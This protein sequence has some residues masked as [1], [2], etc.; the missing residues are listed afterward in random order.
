M[1]LSGL[2]RNSA[3]WGSMGIISPTLPPRRP[4]RLLESIWQVAQDHVH[5]LKPHS[6]ITN[7]KSLASLLGTFQLQ[8]IRRKRIRKP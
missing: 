1:G 6:S 8:K 4:T 5:G 2:Q 3:R 7:L